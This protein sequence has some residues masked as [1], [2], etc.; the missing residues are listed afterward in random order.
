[1]LLVTSLIIWIDGMDHERMYVLFIV[2]R[3][4][5]AIVCVSICMYVRKDELI[6]LDRIMDG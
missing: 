3:K 4:C 5:V 6:D 1:M 2:V